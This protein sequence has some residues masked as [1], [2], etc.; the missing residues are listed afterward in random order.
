VPK[1]DEATREWRKLHN[2]ELNDLYST[3]NIIRV[4]K[5]RRMR[6]AGHIARMRERRVIYWVLVGK[7]E[8]K[9]PLRKPRRKWEDNINMDLQKEGWRGMN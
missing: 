1:R 2:E 4:I 5:T 8:G 9:R 6:W 7:P 3:P